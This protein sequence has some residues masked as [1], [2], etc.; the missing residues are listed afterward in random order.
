MNGPPY[1]EILFSQSLLSQA[2]RFSDVIFDMQK[3][4]LNQIK[5][6]MQDAFQKLASKD[7]FLSV[8]T[9]PHTAFFEE[10]CNCTSKSIRNSMSKEPALPF[11]FPSLAKD[12][13]NFCSN[14]EICLAVNESISSIPRY[15]YWTEITA[16]EKAEDYPVLNSVPYFG[17]SVD[18]EDKS[19]LRLYEYI[20]IPVESDSEECSVQDAIYDRLITRLESGSYSLNEYSLLWTL[21]SIDVNARRRLLKLLPWKGTSN[22]LEA[23]RC[24][25]ELNLK[26]L[27]CSFCGAY[28]CRVHFDLPKGVSSGLFPRK[29][30]SSSFPPKTIPCSQSFCRLSALKIPSPPTP[31]PLS[32]I[33]KSLFDRASRIFPGDSC[34]QSVFLPQRTCAELSFL[35][36]GNH[37]HPPSDPLDSK[38]ND[39]RHSA[40]GASS[41]YLPIFSCESNGAP[42]SFR[43]ENALL[44]VRVE[45]SA[46]IF[47]KDATVQRAAAL[48]HAPVFQCTWNATPV[49]AGAVKILPCAKIHPFNTGLL[50]GK[51]DISGWGVFAAESI[52]KGSF[53]AEYT[54]EIIS[55]IEAE[56]RGFVYDQ[57]KL[58]FL[59]NLNKDFVIDATKKGGLVRFANHSTCPNAIAK[60]MNVLGILRIGIYARANIDAGDEITFDYKYEKEA[61]KFVPIKAISKIKLTTAIPTSFGSPFRHQNNNAPDVHV[62]WMA[63][64]INPSDLN[65]KIEGAY[66]IR[67]DS[68][69]AVAGNEGVGRIVEVLTSGTSLCKGDWV[70]PVSPGTW[71]E[72]SFVCSN[73]LIKVDNTLPLAMA[74]MLH[75]NPCTA[76]RLLDDF[77]IMKPGSLLIQNGANSAVGQSVI[78]IAK[79]KC[80]KTINVIR[81]QRPDYEEIKRHLEELG[82]DMVIS[83]IDLETSSN[84]LEK[85]IIE[86]FGSLPILGL[87]CVGGS[88]ALGLAKLLQNNGLLLTYGA[89]AKRPITLPASL[90]IFKNITFKGFWLSSLDKAADE[91]NARSQRIVSE[92]SKWIKMGTFKLDFTTHP[93][94][95]WQHAIDTAIKSSFTK[96]KQILL[97]SPERD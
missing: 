23:N 55:Q 19:Y 31:R 78:Q 48:R 92:I 45:T 27:V 33:E 14:G 37:E 87:N 16:N 72:E 53:I 10:T 61:E 20:D 89:M 21:S 77:S 65:Q 35:V 7:G 49:F 97:L 28:D 30:N 79:A 91:P 17:D 46:A 41:V 66:P 25:S 36:S 94:D 32:E 6:E 52:V 67:P 22:L 85:K 95:S 43:V 93:M 70:I 63:A 51:S 50:I 60:A 75:V 34:S 58:S 86:K 47:L 39:T 71:R 84:D 96:S 5:R 54:G 13:L 38:N 90:L 12:D 68:F 76:Y 29:K 82:A 42:A 8:Q 1:V 64:P 74:S 24:I 3:K 83:D 26:D 44:P 81:R 56:R 73:D 18:I 2:E 80:F 9:Q 69:P 59:F 57:R 11:V 4:N 62:K 40:A 88:N 15:A